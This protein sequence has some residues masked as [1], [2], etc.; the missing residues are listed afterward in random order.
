MALPPGGCNLSYNGMLPGCR[1]YRY[2]MTGRHLVNV[3]T[4]TMGRHLV[5]VSVVIMG[6]HLVSVSCNLIGRHVM[7]GHT[8]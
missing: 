4:V 5:A 8:I 7:F 2:D 1:V 3:S 6:C